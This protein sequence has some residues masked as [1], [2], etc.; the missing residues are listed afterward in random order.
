MDAL[1]PERRGVAPCIGMRVGRPAE[2]KRQA[3]WGLR[4]PKGDKLEGAEGR[5]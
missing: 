3:A 1:V 2:K 4:A 5:L